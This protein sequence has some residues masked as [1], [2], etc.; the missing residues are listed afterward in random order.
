MML[1]PKVRQSREAGRQGICRRKG[2]KNLVNAAME[3]DLVHRAFAVHGAGP[4]VA[5]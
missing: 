2:R 3:E 1:P 5:D 4:A